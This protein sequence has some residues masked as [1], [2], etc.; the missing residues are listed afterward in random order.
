MEWDLRQHHDADGPY[1]KLLPFEYWQRNCFSAI[2]SGEREVG[3]VAELLGGAD[4]IYRPIFRIST[5][6][7]PKCRRGC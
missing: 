3:S 6:V 2:E 7:S 5:R 1:L 4:N